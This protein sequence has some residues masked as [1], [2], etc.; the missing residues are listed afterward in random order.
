M[1]PSLPPFYRTI[2]SSFSTAPTKA[3]LSFS[4]QRVP[5]MTELVS[6]IHVQDKNFRFLGYRNGEPIPN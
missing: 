6:L 5:A 4:S 2:V 1:T 3:L